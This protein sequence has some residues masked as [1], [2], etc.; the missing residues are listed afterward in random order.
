MAR[1]LGWWPAPLLALTLPLAARPACPE[2]AV[3][4]TE[5]VVVR[6]D[7]IEL[8]TAVVD[9]AGAA[10]SHVA[11]GDELTVVVIARNVSATR[12][13]LPLERGLLATLAHRDPEVGVV[14]VSG[15]AGSHYQQGAVSLDPQQGAE[16]R[17]RL[18]PRVLGPAVVEIALF[19]GPPGWKGAVHA[20][21]P[22][23]VVPWGSTD[24]A[25]RRRREEYGHVF[26]GRG[27]PPATTLS[28]ID[29]LMEF[30][31]DERAVDVLVGLAERDAGLVGDFATA[32]VLVAIGRGWGF[33]G[34]RPLVTAA[35][36]RRTPFRRHVVLEAVKLA[37]ERTHV[38]SIRSPDGTGELYARL[39]PPDLRPAADQALAG[40]LEDEDASVRAAANATAKE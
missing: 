37:R 3:A 26:G 16:R 40:L 29:R 25:A 1:R 11:L 38:V 27:G 22:L 4:T 33:R 18:V 32:Q 31:A 13:L 10:R 21:I 36:A 39:L 5:W 12:Q 34:L 7:G 8:R 6:S 24:Y 14:G 15:G 2:E 28:F 35:W 9:R 19:G 23:T 20:A 30:D 17:V